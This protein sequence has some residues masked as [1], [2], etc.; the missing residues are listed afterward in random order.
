MYHA[1][2]MKLLGLDARPSIQNIARIEQAEQ[3]LGFTFPAAVREWYQ[4]PRA[5]AILAKGSN[6]DIAIPLEDF[7]LDPF[8]V[9]EFV[10]DEFA[11]DEPDLQRL[12]PIKRENQGVCVWSVLLDGSEDPPVM[13]E[14]SRDGNVIRY[15]PTFSEF[16]YTCAWDDA[17]IFQSPF[18][19]QANGVDASMA[20]LAHLKQHLTEELT[21]YGWPADQ[22][23]R[24]RGTDATLLIHGPKSA[25]WYVAAKQIDALETILRLI[26]K[27]ADLSQHLYDCSLEVRDEHA[28]KSLLE[29][30][31]RE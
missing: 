18:V 21:T 1:K 26:W 8:G 20:T 17:L 4:L 5:L 31:R 14:V 2:T 19:L 25:D 23:L 13:V 16:I 6:D 9:D 10:R 3:R 27:C 7:E 12:L 15:A 24:F 30:L 11:A 22:Q 29:R 28:A